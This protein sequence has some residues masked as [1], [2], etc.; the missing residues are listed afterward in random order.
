MIECSVCPSKIKIKSDLLCPLCW[1]AVDKKL[2]TDPESV[3]T[4]FSVLA[5]Q[6][7]YGGQ[8]AFKSLARIKGGN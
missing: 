4:L 6:S 2:T 7:S 5:A 1:N 8:Q 3:E